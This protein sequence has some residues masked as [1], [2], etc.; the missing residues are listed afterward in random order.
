MGKRYKNPPVIEA[1]CEFQFESTASWDLAIPGIIYD[2][3]KQDFPKRLQAS[4]LTV[5]ISPVGEKSPRISSSPITQ[6]WSEDDTFL[7]QI[8]ENLLSVNH[9][10][11]YT[12]WNTFLPMIRNI[13]NIY[14]N[15]AAPERLHGTTLRYINRFEFADRDKDVNDYFELR[16]HI[17]FKLPKE[18]SGF[19][20]IVQIPFE[21]A[22]GML[23][24]H[25]GTAIGMFPNSRSIINLDLAYSLVTSKAALLDNTVDWLENAHKHIEDTFEACITD[26][27]KQT[28]EERAE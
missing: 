22:Q 20:V 18:L 19:A 3:V 12:S 8:G 2:Q 16:P 4:R 23:N 17:G 26:T 15:I 25:V 5:D 9:L 1:L 14:R 27:L 24:V 10:K 28:F 6:F 13:F 11:P 21:E 7:I